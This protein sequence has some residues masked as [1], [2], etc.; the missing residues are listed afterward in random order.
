M[1][2]IKIRNGGNYAHAQYSN[3][4]DNNYHSNRYKKL[5]K[6]A[7][8][9]YNEPHDDSYDEGITA[10]HKKLP[11]QR[12]TP[13]FTPPTTSTRSM[14]V[15]NK[16][17][18]TQHVFTRNTTVPGNSTYSEI[19]K[20]WRQTIIL[21]DSIPKGIRMWEFNKHLNGSKAHIKAF[22]CATAKQLDYYSKPTLVEDAPDC[23]IIHVGCNDIA[24]SRDLETVN[25]E[26]IANDLIGISRSSL[27]HG[28]SKIFISGLICS[29]N[30]IKK[31]I[32]NDVN[33]KLK[34]LFLL[35]EFV[36]IDHPKIRS[37]RLW[38]DGIHLLQVGQGILTN[39]FIDCLN[40]Y[41]LNM[42]EENKSIPELSQGYQNKQGVIENETHFV[43]QL[44]NLR[45]KNVNRIIFAHININSIINKFSQLTNNIHGKIDI[46]MISKTKIDNSFHKNEFTIPAFT[47][48][49]RQDR[50][51]HGG[52]ISLYIRDDIPSKEIKN[53]G[54]CS[55][56]GEFFCLK[57]I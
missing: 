52:G 34:D 35:H 50:N 33:K 26:G 10:L 19:T 56:S 16:R 39:D 4:H 40:N 13:T 8:R 43:T 49:Y 20:H 25:A 51:C 48:P 32:I 30:G 24:K 37:H 6:Q 11:P 28:V 1:E 45:L 42:S 17:P 55:P 15:T 21:S 41:F 22:P 47:E 5:F 46:L 23:L 14:T 7:E 12:R 54:L 53:R 3:A 27:Q 2:P 18:E 36:F 57:S 44:S 38:R 29:K 9:D 31:G